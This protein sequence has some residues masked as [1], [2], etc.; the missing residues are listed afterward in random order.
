MR[1]A[2]FKRKWQRGTSLYMVLIITSVLLAMTLGLETLLV[3]QLKGMREMSNSTIAF[4]AADSGMERTLY[5]NALCQDQAF[6]TSGAPYVG[7]LCINQRSLAGYSPT[8]P[9]IGLYDYSTSSSPGEFSISNLGYK[10][11]VTT[12]VGMSTT[13]FFRSKG[14]FKKNQRAL[15]ASISGG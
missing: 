4:F 13:T 7:D 6:C 3:N 10:I 8:S 12:T 2:K 15:E 1:R 14:I 9:C 11:N 5:L